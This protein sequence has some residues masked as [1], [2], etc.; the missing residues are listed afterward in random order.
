M[1]T[2]ASGFIGKYL[3]AEL[4]SAGWRV[5]AGVHDEHGAESLA[6]W[7]SGAKVVVCGMDDWG[8]LAE[9]ATGEAPEVF[10]HLAWGGYATCGSKGT[11]AQLASVAGSIAALRCAYFTGCDRFVGAGSIHEIEG[12]VDLG[13]EAPSGTPM[14]KYKA[15]KLSAH[16][17]CKAEAT[18]LGID[19]L[20]PKITNAYGPGEV[21]SRLVNTMIRKLL[22][23]ESPDLTDGWQ[24]YTFV[25]ATDVARA[26][27]LIAER[28][29]PFADYVIG[30]E[31]VAPLRIWLERAGVVVAPDV[32]LG[33][34]R[35][36]RG[37]RLEQTELY[38]ESLFSDTGFRT[39]VSFEE[40]IRR[41]AEW[42]R[43]SMTEVKT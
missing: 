15:A 4:L 13:R 2:G 43:G 35:M 20:W 3:V 30:A 7:C 23:G 1:V 26:L 5:V 27:R 19:F 34:G 41:T 18:E 21:S 38:T 37:V 6:S 29:R 40:G 42:M 11:D 36:A 17:L 8:P 25:Y 9:A 32:E 22:T 10:F 12:L 28:G 14:N 24:P 33:F 39:E 31:E 16:H